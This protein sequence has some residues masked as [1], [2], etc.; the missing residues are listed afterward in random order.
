VRTGSNGKISGE[1]KGL[2]DKA[3]TSVRITH[4][5]NYAVTLGRD[6]ALKL[7]DMRRLDQP[8]NTS[9]PDKLMIS[10]NVARLAISPD[11]KLIACG[12]SM[13]GHVIVWPLPANGSL[14]SPIVLPDGG[15]TACATSLSWSP[16]GRG[17]ATLGQD[18]RLVFWR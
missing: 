15:H 2:H 16:D 10:T 12:S 11:S 17:L 14:G 7:V 18:K 9:S 13:G 3:A 8:V 1:I 5:G 4:D 6:N